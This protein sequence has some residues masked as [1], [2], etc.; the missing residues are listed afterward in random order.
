MIELMFLGSAAFVG[1]AHAVRQS[2][3]RN[4]PRQRARRDS[5]LVKAWNSAGAPR[6]EESM[7]GDAVADLGGR[8]IGSTV[9]RTAPR[10]RRRARSAHARAASRWQR[11]TEQDRTVTFFRRRNRSANTATTTGS[12]NPAGAGPGGTRTADEPVLPRGGA[13]RPLPPGS[14]P[15]APRSPIPMPPGHPTGTTMR[16]R[17]TG[18]A[19]RGQSSGRGRARGRARAQSRMRIAVPLDLDAPDTDEEFLSACADLQQM[20]RGIGVAVEDWNDELM[21]RRLPPVVT[22]PLER[23]HEGLVDGAARTALATVLFENWFAEA[24][25]IAAAGIEFTGED[26]E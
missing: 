4:Q 23:V 13:P 12:G 1:G 6:T 17:A 24:R 21:T 3:G 2:R 7:L 22:G 8:A 20:L 18:G 25:E 19:P 5:L 9:R 14:H 15:A 10:V 26:P 11:R 16:G